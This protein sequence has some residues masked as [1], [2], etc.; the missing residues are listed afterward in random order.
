MAQRSGLKLRGRFDI[1]DRL[2][3]ACSAISRPVSSGAVSHFWIMW[4]A[5]CAPPS[6]TDGV[7]VL[8]AQRKLP[9]MKTRRIVAVTDL[10][11]TV[12]SSKNSVGNVFQTSRVCSR[13]NG[14]AGRCFPEYTSVVSSRRRF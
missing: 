12:L 8:T 4:S 11:L 1:F 10:E 7:S 3:S 9:G 14:C 13:F 6:E 5:H 2:P